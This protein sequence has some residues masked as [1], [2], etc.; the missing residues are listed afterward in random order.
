LIQLYQLEDEDAKTWKMTD[1]IGGGA[2]ICNDGP[3]RKQRYYRA[4]FV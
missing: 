4:L 3:Q 2:G 1:Q